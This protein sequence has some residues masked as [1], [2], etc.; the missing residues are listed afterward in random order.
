MS[1]AQLSNPLSI[2]LTHLF[3]SQTCISFLHQLH[4]LTEGSSMWGEKCT[5]WMSYHL[6]TVACSYSSI[7]TPTYR[8]TSVQKELYC[9]FSFSRASGG[10]RGCCWGD[11][12]VTSGNIYFREHFK[13]LWQSITHGNST[14][15]TKQK[16]LV[17]YIENTYVIQVH[18]FTCWPKYQEC[19]RPGG[20]PGW[21]ANLNLYSNA[22]SK[23]F[24]WI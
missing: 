16:W 6:I 22:Y 1:W 14:Y 11:W 7:R 24:S 18:Y 23:C 2:N 21:T 20:P 5:P 19:E 13:L 17:C 3:N 8:V 15:K 9:C 12:K 10:S 4:D